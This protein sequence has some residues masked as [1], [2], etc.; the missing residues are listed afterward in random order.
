MRNSTLLVYNTKMD[1]R[2]NEEWIAD[3]RAGGEQQAQAL[4]D[5][6]AIIL[7]GLPYAIAGR[8]APNSPESE[9]LVEEIVQETLMR[10]LDNLDTFEGRSQFTTW[11]HK[12]AVRAAL[13]ELRRVRWREVPLPE[14][15]M[16]DDEDNS[17][18]E[19]PDHQPSPE[20]QMGRKDM[21]QHVNRIIMEELTEKQRKALMAI[22]E[23]FPLEEAAQR[24][25]MNRNAL[26]KLMHDARL[27]L[28]KRLE[29]EG[30]TPKEVLS[31][32]E[33]VGK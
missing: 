31:V 33:Q 18:R 26:Y 25:G 9:A 3:L 21:M 10:V 13:T 16:N 28:K 17:Y 30:L 22:M 27:R 32:F 1:K 4:E 14:M 24:L 5:L 19:L 6:R 11:A 8:I 29:K 23:G 7:R 15:G 12:I 2:T 20:D